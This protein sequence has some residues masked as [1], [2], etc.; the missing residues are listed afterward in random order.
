MYKIICISAYNRY[1]VVLLQ[2]IFIFKKLYFKDFKL[3]PVYFITRLELVL[4]ILVDATCLSAAYTHVMCLD[5]KQD[6]REQISRIS[7]YILYFLIFSFCFALS[8]LKYLIIIFDVSNL[9]L[10]FTCIS[11]VYYQ[12]PYV[13]HITYPWYFSKL[14]LL[15][16]S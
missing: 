12:S 8:N 1:N 10:I 2:E 9:V 11:K 13:P 15:I 4:K 16:K 6:I 7:C 14:M 3:A 5:N